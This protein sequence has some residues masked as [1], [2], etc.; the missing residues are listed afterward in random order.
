MTRR[1]DDRLI[2]HQQR[3]EDVDAAIL[4]AERERLGPNVNPGREVSPPERRAYAYGLA[5]GMEREREQI[6]GV[7]RQYLLHNSQRAVSWHEVQDCIAA[8]RAQ[9]KGD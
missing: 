7:I 9:A 8:I 1:M 2:D 6:I 4:A 5:A 3:M